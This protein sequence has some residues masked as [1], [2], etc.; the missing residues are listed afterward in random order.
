[1]A[2]Y[3]QKTFENGASIY[4]WEMTE[5]E[6]DLI[7]SYPIPSNDIQEISL[8]KSEKKR[9][10]KLAVRA[11]LSVIFN[12][13]TYLGH[14]ENGLPFLQNKLEKISISHSDRFVAIIIHEEERVAI[15]IERLNRDFSAVEKKALSKKEIRQLS[16]KHRDLHLAICWSCKESVFKKMST[17]NVNFA[18]QIAIKKFSPDDE[19]TLEVTFIHQDGDKDE[20]EVFYEIVDNHIMTWIIE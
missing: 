1:M 20:M 2:L 11:L 13:K 9:I 16:T 5:S 7:D 4:V 10:E 3:L 19:G 17:D 15:D 12:E 14:H 18:E 6:S 8:L